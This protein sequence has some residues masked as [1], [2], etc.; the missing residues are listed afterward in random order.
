[1][2]IISKSGNVRMEE[3]LV[4]ENVEYDDFIQGA[5]EVEQGEE[6]EVVELSLTS[7]E[8]LAILREALKIVVK[9]VNDNEIIMKSLLKIQTRIREE[10]QREKNEKQKWLLHK[11]KAKLMNLTN[12]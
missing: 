11:M 7:K 5:I 4:E 1:M 10:V 8:K 12:I 6:E 9:M 3:N 2:P